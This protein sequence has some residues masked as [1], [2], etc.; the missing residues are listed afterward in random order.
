MAIAQAGRE[1]HGPE[2]VAAKEHHHPLA[3]PGAVAARPEQ[4]SPEAAGRQDP[5]EQAHRRRHLVLAAGGIGAGHQD[6]IE[7]QIGGWLQG[8]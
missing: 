7:G 4:E 2:L 1:Q 8:P 6:Q 5:I 3:R